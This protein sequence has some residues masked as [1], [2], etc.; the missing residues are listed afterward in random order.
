[1]AES[2]SVL[3]AILEGRYRVEREIGAG[4]MATV[5][6]AEDL[7]HGR[8]VALKVLKP[9][10]VAAIGSERFLAEI[11][12]TARLQHPHIL[13]L[14][15]SG[16]AGSFLFYVMPYVDGETLADR[17]R[18]ERQLPVE[19]AVRICTQV[20]RALAYAHREG[21]IHRDIK[22]ANVLLR[23]ED[24]LLAD[25]G[26]AL[27]VGEGSERLTETGL[28]LGTP[29]Y[30]SPEQAT[31]DVP[32]GPASDIWSL[33]CILY[34]MLAGVSPFGAGSSQAVLGRIVAGGVEPLEERRPAAPAN[35]VAAVAKA[36]EKVPADRFRS[37]EDLAAALADPAFRHGAPASTAGLRWGPIVAAVAAAYVLGLGTWLLLRGGGAAPPA[38]VRFV[39]EGPRASGLGRTLTISPD[40]G[41]VAHRGSGGLSLHRVGDFSPPITLVE[42]EVEQPFFSPDGRSIGYFAGVAQDV[43]RVSVIDGSGA[44]IAEGT[45]ARAMGGSWGD[46]GTI[47]FAT[48]VG[49]YRVSAEGGEPEL[50]TAPDREG[51]E[52]FFSWP[53]LLP[54]ARSVLYT[55]VSEEAESDADG[56]IACMDLE[57][58]EVRTVIRGGSAPRLT[59]TGHLVFTAEAALRAVAFDPASCEVR[60]ER[61]RLSIDGLALGRAWGADFDISTDGTLV[62]MVPDQEPGRLSWVDRTGREEPLSQPP[63]SYT[64]A[65]VSP[66]GGRIAVD[67]GSP[68]LRDIYI[69]DA[70]RGGALRVTRDAGEEFFA[71]WSPSGDS[72]Y[73]SSNELGGPFNIFRRAADGTGSSELVFESSTAEMLN[74]VSE[75]GLLVFAEAVAGSDPFDLMAIMPGEATRPDTILSTAAAEY[76]AMVSPDGAYVAYQSDATGQYEV[77]V[78][79]LRGPVRRAGRSRSTEASARP[80]LPPGTPS[81]TARERTP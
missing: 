61:V 9:E 25:L 75:D 62:Y 18:R 14:F 54:G 30:M 59:S 48:T 69:L 42:G 4:G 27:A 33:G 80:G 51:G 31:G 63:R 32:V 24:V 21:V 45:G 1:M 23:G 53:L 57:T 11:R 64:Y 10:L 36:L 3:N 12:T 2:I 58:R 16:E 70:D 79:P 8:K 66:D 17:L 13:P 71:E 81:S 41:L 20:V 6:L 50:L 67:V 49:L 60:G 72:I 26:I 78:S 19:D 52:L 68:G 39:I 38:P 76:D 34:E 47:V 73:F 65:R 55:V 40:G 22:P 5:Y 28:S 7:R 77:Y 37:A 43:A 46:E 56:A 15:D 35:V 74:D 29:Q 44:V